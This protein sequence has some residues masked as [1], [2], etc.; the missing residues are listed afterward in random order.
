MITEQDISAAIAE[1]IG[2]RT[3]NANTCIKLAAFYTIRDAMFPKSPEMTGQ[4]T[5]ERYSYAPAAVSDV[6]I[7][8]NSEF[9]EMIN[10]RRQKDVWPI[11]D[12]LMET[13]HLVQPRLYAAVLEKLR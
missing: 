4:G 5:Q 1:C 9:A 2:E 8:S 3:P 7:N 12:E 13:L 11:I 10:G 6:E